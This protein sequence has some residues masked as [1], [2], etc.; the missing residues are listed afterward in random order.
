MKRSIQ[1]QSVSAFAHS[2]P[3]TVS[4]SRTIRK[5]SSAR[6][7]HREL[8]SAARHNGGSSDDELDAEQVLNA[9]IS[10]RKGDF[11]V[12]LPLGWTGISGK[13]AD[14]FNEVTEMMSRSTVELSRISRV[15]GKEG[16]IQERL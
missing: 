13:V 11:G 2:E 3:A 8:K 10:L 4:G 16:K 9:L 15:V 6:G 1:T 7:A 14:A 12:R 5:R